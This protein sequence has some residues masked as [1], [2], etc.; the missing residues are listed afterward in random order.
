MEVE[1]E[2]GF[3]D[4]VEKDVKVV[5]Y[6]FEYRVSDYIL[7]IKAKIVIAPDNHSDIETRCNFGV[8]W[9]NLEQSDENL[10]L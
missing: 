10:K 7:L 5:Y 9:Q 1:D 8:L 4:F 2:V 3:S 6:I